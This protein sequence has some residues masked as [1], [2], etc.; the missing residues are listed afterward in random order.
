MYA[1]A[2]IQ[3]CKYR[4]A[5]DMAMTGLRIMILPYGLAE[6]P[7]EVKLLCDHVAHGRLMIS[8]CAEGVENKCCAF[9]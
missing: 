5:P 3:C 6:D 9:T 7:A 4:V 1:L 8:Y 2:R